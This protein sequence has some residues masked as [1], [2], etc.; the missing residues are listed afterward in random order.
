MGLAGLFA[1]LIFVASAAAAG[2]EAAAC[3][4]GISV[5]KSPRVGS[6]EVQAKALNDRGDVVGFADG[7][8][9]T[10][11]AI[12]WK[13]G[14]AARAVN[15]GVLPGYVSSEAYGVNNHRVVFGLLYDKKERTFPFR[16]VGRTVA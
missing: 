15:L 4:P 16:S 5:L 7:K 3:S 8:D 12:L 1:S 2:T 13:G 9:G 10:D 6:H 14:K 11:R